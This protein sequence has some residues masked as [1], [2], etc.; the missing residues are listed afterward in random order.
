MVT[1]SLAVP[2]QGSSFRGEIMDSQC[3]QMGSHDN[4]MKQEGAKNAKECSDACVKM[5][6]KY[7]LYDKGTKTIYQLDD[8]S[9]RIFRSEGDRYRQR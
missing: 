4:M 9:Q 8:L 5:G 1:L 7:V 6:G 3:A 2:P